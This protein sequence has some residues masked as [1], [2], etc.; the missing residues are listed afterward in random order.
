MNK[1]LPGQHKYS[2]QTDQSVILCK[3]GEAISIV[4]EHL[5][6]EKRM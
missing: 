4:T 2:M 1:L 6:A 5:E 3:D